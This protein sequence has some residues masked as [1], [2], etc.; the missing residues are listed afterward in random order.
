MKFNRSF[1]FISFSVDLFDLR[2]MNTLTF[3]FNTLAFSFNTPTFSCNT[4]DFIYP[5]KKT[6]P[7]KQGKHNN[8]MHT[9]PSQGQKS[10]LWSLAHRHAVSASRHPEA[11]CVLGNALAAAGDH[12][13]AAHALAKA[14][15]MGDKAASITPARMGCSRSA[16]RGAHTM[17]TS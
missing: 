6:Q 12:T 13:R 11:C 16:V 1:H 10:E 8:A 5:Q 9:T 3:S 15:R 17:H 4:L 7:E 2:K 14:A